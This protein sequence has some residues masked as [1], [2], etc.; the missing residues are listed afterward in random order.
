MS[1]VPKQVDLRGLTCPEPVIRAKKLFD[2]P[3][4]KLVEALV[5][6]DVCVNNLQRLAR[7]LKTNFAVKNVGSYYAVTMERSGSAGA[8][9]ATTFNP[10]SQKSPAAAGQTLPHA[11]EGLAVL[12]TA[13]LELDQ[14]LGT[15][16]VI[17]IAKDTFGQGD[18]EFSRTLMNLFLQT[19]FE[20]GFRPRAILLANTGVRLLAKNSPAVRVLDDFQ[21]AGC[22]VLACGLC[23]DFY[24]LKDDIAKEQI[25]NMFAICEYLFAAGKVIQP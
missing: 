17:F 10:T 7:S 25:T 15:S 3:Q 12:P 22:A 21:Q 8:T 23:V 18:E 1:N 2:D 6:D 16:T 19:T 20:S 24:K 4:T 13:E 9:T 14:A 11:H 5:D